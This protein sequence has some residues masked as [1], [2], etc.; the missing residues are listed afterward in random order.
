MHKECAGLAA[1]EIA[2]TAAGFLFYFFTGRTVAL[3]LVIGMIVLLAGTLYFF[4]D[5]ERN[6]S[7]QTGN[8]VSPADGKIIRIRR[9]YEQVFCKEQVTTVAIF[10]RLWDVHVNRMPVDGKIRFR[11]YRSGRFYPAMSNKASIHNE[12]MR[13]GFIN[14]H[15]RFLVKLVAGMIARR[16]VCHVRE[17][18]SVLQGQRIGMIKFGSQVELSLPRCYRLQVK[19][20][21]I[22]KAGETV[23]AVLDRK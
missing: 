15:G 23:I 12:Q 1:G 10:L 21:Q 14:S 8:V 7:T 20:N 17:G 18:D 3:I 9:H 4:R 11:E 13:I 22:I 6:I 16:I 5:P 2:L 19:E